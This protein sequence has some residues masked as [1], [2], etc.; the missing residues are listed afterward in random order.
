MRAAAGTAQDAQGAGV[1]QDAQDTH[2]FRDPQGTVRERKPVPYRPS[3]VVPVV[4]ALV[5]AG[6]VHGLGA[7]IG[8]LLAV[9]AA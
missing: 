2:D 7:L 5:C 8:L 4:T 3:F 6:A 9:L 1:P